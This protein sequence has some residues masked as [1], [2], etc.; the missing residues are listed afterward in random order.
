VSLVIVRNGMSK[1]LSRLIGLSVA[2]ALLA[3]YG[4]ATPTLLHAESAASAAASKLGSEARARAARRTGWSRVIVRAV[5]SSS[6]PQMR[7]VIE[8]AGGTAGRRLGLVNGQVGEVPNAAL[9]GLTRN[10]FVAY[11]TLDRAVAGAIGRT[12][13]TV[14][15]NDVRRDL[16]YNGRG[17]G[18]AVI[19]SGVT[20]SH[21]DMVG[22]DGNQ[23][24]V[25]FVDLMNGWEAPY[26]DY[27]HG[28]HVAG[29][30]GGT[31][32]QSSGARSGIA[33]GASLI[34]LKAL[35]AVG[36]GRISDVI[37]ALD[38][39]V[40]NRAALNIRVV[41]L[42]LASG[43]H[44]SYHTDP[45]ALATRR[46]VEAGIVVVAAAGNVGRDPAGIPAYGGI[47][48]PGNAPWVLTVGASNHRG[49]S[50][51]SD[52]TMA[53][54]TSR[55]PTAIDYAAKPDIVAP[56]VGI[57]SLSAPESALYT[58]LGAYLLGAT[59][60]TPFPPY[61]SLS[62]TS[63]AAPVVS[64]TVALML[65]ANPALTPNQVKA[66]LQYTSREYS[67]H[68][69]LTQG[70]GFLNA[71]AAVELA[72]YFAQ[73]SATSGDSSPEYPSRTGLS[74]RIVWGNR[75]I[76]GGRLT[77]SATAWATDVMWGAAI[78]P[79]G[80]NVSW[81]EICSGDD[82]SSDS[83]GW[84][85]WATQCA[86][87]TCTSVIWGS[88]TVTNVVWG[89]TCGGEDCQGPWTLSTA[90]STIADLTQATTVVWG[91]NDG[92]TVLWGSTVVWGTGCADPACDPVI[93]IGP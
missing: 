91:T 48:S 80:E 23:Q 77:P 17:V 57:E 54:F 73:A 69:G 3:A 39:V 59:S 30:I 28:T 19:D 15:A 12:G 93:W 20:P 34:V 58:R 45:L 47:T 6:L 14:G 41:N 66:I 22:A 84:T 90:A 68:D 8:Q 10:P 67:G 7:R 51:R 11:V 33:P 29:I 56:G 40:V 32:K 37:A 76:K 79:R 2:L 24:V 70:A 86:D 64:G 27:G 5:D 43:V 65:Q 9:N 53:L 52:D 78:T 83:A 38:Y 71:K 46:A 92:Q 13:K 60:E 21:G 25:R 74:R 1:S 49:T 42:S 87:Q 50:D 55:G 88:G 62:G 75:L 4:P 18:V 31:G 63:M 26:D 35:D 85:P 89:S 36:G 44:E 82:C 81:G 16:G 61:L 72:R